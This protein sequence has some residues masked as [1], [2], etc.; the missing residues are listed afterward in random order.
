MHEQPIPFF[1][2]P[3]WV[4]A[5]A[6]CGFNVESVFR[7]LGIETDLIHLETATITI[8]QLE[9][10]MDA[11]IAHTHQGHFPFTL[12]ETFAFDYLPDLE[13]FINTSNNLREASRVFVWV[14]ELI[15]PMLEVRLEEHD[16]NAHL[17]LVTLNDRQ[18]AANIKPYFCETTFASILKFGRNLLGE[19][20]NFGELRFRH[21][22][23]AYVMEYER[24]FRLPVRFAQPRDELV[25]DRAL[26]D[27]PLEGGFPSLHRQA[28][29]RADQLLRQAPK[30]EGLAAGIE[31]VYAQDSQLIGRGIE[32]VAAVLKL[33]PRTLQRRLREEGTSFAEV[34]DRARYRAAMASLQQ[35]ET[36]LED[37][38]EQLGF[39]D[40]RSFT[41]AFKRWSGLSPSAFRSHSQA[42]R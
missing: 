39:S 12:G 41:R 17:V 9:Q 40:R 38:S 13:T 5:A 25:F 16:N 22:T 34:H 27:L 28:E 14:R 29:Y 33:H 26:L 18:D 36:K 15:N 37:L 30:R 21:R 3:N 2:L 24:H 31:Q 20:E 35:G 7:D 6:K 23:P 32:A 11:C 42:A 1:T 19:Q 4:K 8:P 10:V